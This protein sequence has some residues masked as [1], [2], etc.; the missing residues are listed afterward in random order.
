MYSACVSF[1]LR[2]MNTGT[3][4]RERD[5]QVSCCSRR[6]HACLELVHP[7]FSRFSDHRDRQAHLRQ[8]K[9]QENP[10]LLSIR[11]HRWPIRS[12]GPD[13]D[14]TT[15]LFNHSRG[16]LQSSHHGISLEVI[17]LGCHDAV[18]DLLV[19][20]RDCQWY[21]WVNKRAWGCLPCPKSLKGAFT[22]H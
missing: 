8:E 17:F 11:A 20:K 2:E 21:L 3:R 7:H 12:Q 5:D 10:L 9:R 22:L 15:V 4:N 13:D 6:K 16:Q 19:G 1:E 14:V 18:A